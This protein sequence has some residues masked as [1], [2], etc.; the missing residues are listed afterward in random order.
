[1]ECRNNSYAK[2][3]ETLNPNKKQ[4]QNSPEY[5]ISKKKNKKYE[6]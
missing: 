5:K 6:F 4:K 3:N 1:M 2:K